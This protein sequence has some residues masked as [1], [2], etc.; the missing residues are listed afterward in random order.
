MTTKAKVIIISSTTI[1][2]GGIAWFFFLRKMNAVTPE[3]K[4]SLKTTMVLPDNTIAATMTTGE[5]DPKIELK[6][7]GGLSVSELGAL[8]GTGIYN[9]NSK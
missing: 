7:E 5:N 6:P 4:L 3:E 1:V 2:L 8:V 9:P